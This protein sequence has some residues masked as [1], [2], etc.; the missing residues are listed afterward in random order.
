MNAPGDDVLKRLV[1][2]TNGQMYS[3]LDDLPS[4]AFATGYISRH[5]LEESQNSVYAPGTGQYTAELAAALTKALV[6]IGDELTN[7][8]AIGYTSSNDRMDGDFR[9]VEI[10]T[11]RNDVELRHKKGYYAVP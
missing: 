7:Q 1:R 2:E 10:R 5:Q 4:T 6:A 8:Y 3:P 9:S 11:R